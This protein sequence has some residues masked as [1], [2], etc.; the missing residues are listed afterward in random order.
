[1]ARDFLELA[2]SDA[3][4]IKNYY[5]TGGTALAGFYYQH[6]LSEDIDLFCEDHEINPILTEA[7]LK[8]HSKKLTID[9]WKRTQILGLVSYMLLYSDGEKLKVDFNYYP[10][11]QVLISCY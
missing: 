1:L 4:I 3:Y 11:N 5:L 6:R 9:N 2:Q 8:K 10:K 7:F